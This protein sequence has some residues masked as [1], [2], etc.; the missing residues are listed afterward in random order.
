MCH[1]RQIIKTDWMC[2]IF[3]SGIKNVCLQNFISTSVDN[4]KHIM[5]FWEKPLFEINNDKCANN[6]TKH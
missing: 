5:D 1:L 6:N 3:T 4:A 2:L